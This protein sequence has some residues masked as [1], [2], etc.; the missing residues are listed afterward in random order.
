MLLYAWLPVGVNF[1]FFAKKSNRVPWFPSKKASIEAD[2]RLTRSS[3]GHRKLE[4]LQSGLWTQA[5]RNI[6]RPPHCAQLPRRAWIRFLNRASLSGKFPRIRSV[7]PMA[8]G[9]G[10]P[11]ISSFKFLLVCHQDFAWTLDCGR[12]FDRGSH[13]SLFEWLWGSLL[14]AGLS[15][16]LH[17]AVWTLVADAPRLQLVQP[18]SISSSSCVGRK[19]IM[20]TRFFL[21]GEENHHDDSL[22]SH[23]MAPSLM[24]Q[25]RHDVSTT[26]YPYHFWIIPAPIPTTRITGSWGANLRSWGL[27]VS[28]LKTLLLPFLFALEETNKVLTC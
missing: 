2:R 15:R 11:Q 23:Y 20:T 28:D 21:C 17:I 7:V 5:R 25:N 26:V 22:S 24:F 1:R 14:L 12:S 19:S 8:C 9:Q 10:S 13:A 3:L 6:L 18:R 4:V 16:W 27:R